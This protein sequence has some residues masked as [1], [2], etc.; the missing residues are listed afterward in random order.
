MSSFDAFAKMREFIAASAERFESIDPSSLPGLDEFADAVWQSSLRANMAGQ[1]FVRLVEAPETQRVR[2]M[3]AGVGNA[4]VNLPWEEA[5]DAFTSRDIVTP[6]EFDAMADAEKARA[7]IARK[8]AGERMVDAAK[9]ELERTLREGG[10]L[11]DFVAAMRDESISLGTTPDDP[12]YL[13]VIFRTNTLGA[14][15]AGRFR[16]MTDPIV[17]EARPVV[18]YVTVG[19]DRVRPNHAALDG[20]QWRSGDTTWHRIAPP[21]GFACRCAAVMRSEPTGRL[22]R[23]IPDDGQPDEGFDAPPL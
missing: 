21:N 3:E 22:R 13:E 19:D 16:Q 20:M 17:V 2:A 6:E 5:I 8:L 15:G 4:F 10:T 7:F 1:L 18:E 9:R 12:S 23:G 14:Y 11:R